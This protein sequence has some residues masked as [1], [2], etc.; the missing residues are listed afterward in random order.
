[1]SQQGVFHTGIRL[2][3][4]AVLALLSLPVAA[5]EVT[6]DLSTNGFLTLAATQI[7][8]AG[9]VLPSASGSPQALEKDKVSFDGS[10]IG[11]QLDYKV[12]DDLSFSAQAV[13]S[14]QIDGSYS[15]NMEWAN[16]KYDLGNDFYLRGGQF[17]LPFMQ[18]TELRYVG[19]SRL[20]VRPIVPSNGAGGFDEYT[21]L[22]VIKAMV[23]DD[24]NLRFEAAYGKSDHQQEFVD[25]KDIKLLSARIEKD[26]S[27]LNI[28]LV[29]AVYDVY[30]NNMLNLIQENAEMMMG[31][32]EAEFLFDSLIINAGYAYGNAE[33]NP[34]ETLTYLSI[35]YRLGDLTPFIMHNTRVMDFT[36]PAGVPPPPPG[37]PA[38]RDGEQ[39]TETM[40]LGLRYDIAAGYAIK[41]QWDHREDSDASNAALGVQRSDANIY[42]LVL[43]G[44]F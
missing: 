3:A 28:A 38:F 14:K 10:L 22:E 5:L 21:G 29:Q 42:T 7:D 15:P 41:A 6:D 35:G 34:D 20:W 2:G 30:G 33:V 18:G 43:E 23:V 11:L 37:V 31:S 26:E 12:T 32:A 13:G 4:A 24:F 39:K 19:Y 1:M 44:F 16:L 25:N 36:A 8:Y 27:W 9:V 17:K 40:A